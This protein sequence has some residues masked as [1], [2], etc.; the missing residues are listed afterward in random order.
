MNKT[1]VTDING[2]ELPMGATVHP[3]AAFHFAYQ[4][5][6]TAGAQE[7]RCTPIRNGHLGLTPRAIFTSFYEDSS[8]RGTFTMG[9]LL[10]RQMLAFEK[11]QAW[12]A[13][14]AHQ[15]TLAA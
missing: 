8:A 5:R 11:T 14:L 13:D 12:L 1:Y 3:D 6:N 4:G 9:W 15:H 2:T 10:F 7:W